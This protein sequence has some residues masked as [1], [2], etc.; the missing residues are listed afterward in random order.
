ML[1]LLKSAHPRAHALQPEKPWQWEA[2]ALQLEGN[3]HSPQ[4]ETA[5]IQQQGSREAKTNK[6]ELRDKESHFL[7]K[8]Y[9]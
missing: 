5:H 4:L 8:G 7:L 3:P 1:Q 6:L 9:T 2:S